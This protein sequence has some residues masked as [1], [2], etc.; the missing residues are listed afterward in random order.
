MYKPYS[1]EWNRYRYLSEAMETY[2]NDGVPP[3]DLVNDI[4]DVLTSKI[5]NHEKEIE[6]LDTIIKLL[7][8]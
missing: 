6:N 2:I 7:N 5:S 3:E 1:P 8:K 4:F